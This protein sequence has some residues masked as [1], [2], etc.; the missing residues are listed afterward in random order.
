MRGELLW[1]NETRQDGLIRTADGD[2]VVVL[3]GSFAAGHGPV[4]RCAGIPVTFELVSENGEARAVS[5]TLLEPE[6]P[7]RARSRSRR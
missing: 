1:F 6:A 5:V 3:G 2:D 7:R 4:G